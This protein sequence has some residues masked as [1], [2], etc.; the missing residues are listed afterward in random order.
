MKTIYLMRHGQTLFNTMDVNQ[1]Q[2]DSPLTE[3]G[4][5]Q[6]L[7]AKAWYQRH[8]VH[9]DAV[10]SSTSERACDTAELASGGMPYTRKKGLKEIYLGTKEASPNSENPAYPYGDYFVKYGGEDLDAFTQRVYDAVKEIA[11]TE[12]GDVILVVSHGLAIRRFLTVVTGCQ[13]QTL[14]FLGNCGI[15]K[16]RYA[17]GK[18]AVEEIIDPNADV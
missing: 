17:D 1:G 13:P 12:T 3:Q 7:A 2:C 10:Y 16:L 4:I 18:F 11:D 14:G 8:N 9:F 6:A 15:A 5:Q